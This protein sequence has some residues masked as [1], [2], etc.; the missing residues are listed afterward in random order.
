MS[1]AHVVVT[2][3]A[4]AMAA[5][6]GTVVLR[7]ADWIMKSFADYGVPASWGPALGTTKLAGAV[8][9]LVGL[10][11][12]VVGV[13]AGIGLVLYFL[14]AAITVVRARWYAHVPFPLV[15]MA[16]VVG[17]LALGLAA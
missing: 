17:S 12:P 4:A 15:Y 2:V 3:L 14:G 7:R 8:G 5:F 10:F 9:L 13:L 16:P 1:V 6:S 11:L